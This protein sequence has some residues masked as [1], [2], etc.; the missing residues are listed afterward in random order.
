MSS[1][2]LKTRIAIVGG[3]MGGLALAVALS[4]LEAE[5]HLDINVYESASKLTE[6]G[7][8]IN[9]WPRG[10]EIMRNMGLEESLLS[11]LSSAEI[12]PCVEELRLPLSLKK[13]NQQKGTPILNFNSS[14][15]YGGTFPFHR[16]DVQ[17]VLLDH[18]SPSIP[19][20]LS[21]RLAKFDETGEGVVL[22]FTN[23]STATCDLL[24]G[25]D[26]IHSFVRKSLLAESLG[27]SDEEAGKRARP[28]WTG[29]YAYRH[30]I[31]AD[32]L[33][34]DYPDH[35]A[36]KKMMIYCGKNKMLTAYPIRQGKLINLAPMVFHPESAGTYLNDHGV[37]EITT[38]DVASFYDNWEDEVR[39]LVKFVTHPSKW[40]IQ[41]V[42]P[43]DS[44]ISSSGRVL[45][46]GDSA[47][48]TP[49]YF[50]NGA[51]LSIESAYLLAAVIDK[52]VKTTNGTVDVSKI[53]KVYNTIR[54][55]YCNAAAANSRAL[56]SQYQFN[57]PGFEQYGDE[58]DVPKEKMSE[59]SKLM[60]QGWEW[61][62]TS[63]M[64]DLER[65]LAML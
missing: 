46:L 14:G 43:M 61:T 22:T 63:V 29:V 64:P 44:Y 10:W 65:A 62:G 48:A 60:S 37:H 9:F 53:S 30:I 5:D 36:L 18:L 20:H 12:K 11:K 16:A 17:A 47:H 57:I 58:E 50:A 2:T 25:A 52:A 8:G 23:G 3:G 42:D 35:P 56:G 4:K 28:L 38:D 40:A 1:P 32:A 31:D 59:L 54:Q 27:I 19:C 41:Y 39:A 55:P 51:G 33:R 21:H 49:P 6:V 24:I 7:A 34:R 15:M 26:G 13:G 45:L